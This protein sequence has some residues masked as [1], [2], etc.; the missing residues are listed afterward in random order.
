M[1]I[2]NERRKGERDRK[3]MKEAKLKM[4]TKKCNSETS[5]SFV[6]KKISISFFFQ[7]LHRI[8]LLSFRSTQQRVLQ[9]KKKWNK[10]RRKLRQN[11]TLQLFP[12]HSVDRSMSIQP[13]AACHLISKSWFHFDFS[14]LIT[15]LYLTSHWQ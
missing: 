6:R 13:T 14:L 10:I 15:Y 5:E 1:Y 12:I 11:F 9:K 7:F 8:M 3:E 4:N 2:A